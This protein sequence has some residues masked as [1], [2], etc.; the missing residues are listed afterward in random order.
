MTQAVG[1]AD[2]SKANRESPMKIEL[3]CKPVAD[4]QKLAS[5]N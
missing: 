4:N 1:H 2:L 3:S 5:H